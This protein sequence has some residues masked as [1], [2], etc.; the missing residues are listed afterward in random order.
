MFLRTRHL[1]IHTTVPLYHVFN[2]MGRKI[3]YAVTTIV[4]FRREHT[5]YLI[6][7]AQAKIPFLSIEKRDFVIC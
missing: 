2:A 1:P 5:F 4:H 6:Q 3:V 7:V